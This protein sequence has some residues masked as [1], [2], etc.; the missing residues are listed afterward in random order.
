MQVFGMLLVSAEVPEGLTPG[1]QPLVLKV[2]E[3]D[4]SSRGVTVWRGDF[5]A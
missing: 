2:G 4:N 3:N 1:A 5:R